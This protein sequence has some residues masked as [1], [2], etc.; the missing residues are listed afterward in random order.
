MVGR[1]CLAPNAA[2][3]KLETIMTDAQVLD[4]AGG[5]AALRTSLTQA[6][7]ALAKLEA[8][9]AIQAARETNDEPSLAGNEYAVPLEPLLVEWTPRFRMSMPPEF[10]TLPKRNQAMLFTTGVDLG[11]L[12]LTA[13]ASLG[14]QKAAGADRAASDIAKIKACEAEGYMRQRVKM[15]G[16]N[17]LGFVFVK[18]GLAVTPQGAEKL[19]AGGAAPADQEPQPSDQY[20]SYERAIRDGLGAP[21]MLEQIRA[22]ERLK[23]GEDE[24]LLAL[25]KQFPFKQPSRVTKGAARDAYDALSSSVT[26]YK[27]HKDSELRRADVLGILGPKMDTVRDMIARGWPDGVTGDPQSLLDAAQGIIDWYN[28]IKDQEPSGNMGRGEAWTYLVSDKN[29]TPEQADA[30]LATPTSMERS[31]TIDRPQY[32]VEY[33]NAQADKALAAVV[34]DPYDVALQMQGQFNE[35][36]GAISQALTA[37]GIDRSSAAGGATFTKGPVSVFYSAGDIHAQRTLGIDLAPFSKYVVKVEGSIG[38][39]ISDDLADTPEQTAAR[40]IDEVNKL[41]PATPAEPPAP[42]VP[43][44]NDL[45]RLNALKRAAPKG[46]ITSDDPNALEKL[47]AKL[48]ALMAEQEFMKKANKFIKANKDAELMAMGFTQALIDGLK[49]PDFAGRIGFADYML[50]NNNGVIATTR[51]RIASIEAL[52]KKSATNQEG[53]DVTE[54]VQQTTEDRDREMAAEADAVAG[55]GREDFATGGDGTPSK[56]AQFNALIATKYPGPAF[57]G[58]VR[59]LED[60]F[61]SAYAQTKSEAE[62]AASEAAANTLPDASSEDPAYVQSIIDGKVDLLDP[63]IYGRLE[64]LFSKYADDAAMMGLL[65]QAAEVYTAAAVAAAKGA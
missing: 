5:I 38:V 18:D 14:G 61:R 37:A 21:G 7:T 22:D 47:R 30:I 49:K 13:S 54:P 33:L 55:M 27:S 60:D 2:Q 8:A 23:E 44:D 32:S 52:M 45:A 6:P 36:A 62:Q 40:I 34:P 1:R 56:N 24:A 63:G 20:L 16:L 25:A 11:M 48:A 58:R 12:Q 39:D 53:Q 65:N 57:S 9:K 51:K 19:A 35:R 31:G 41:Q 59:E 46:A 10:R 50:S 3:L 43:A 4:D 64:P 26:S 17:I 29:L 15:A 28:R 42:A